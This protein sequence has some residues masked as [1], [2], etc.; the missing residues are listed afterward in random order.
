MDLSEIEKAL[1]SLDQ[2]GV[3]WCAP[4]PMRLSQ[5]AEEYFYLSAESSY[6]EQRWRCYPPQR[7]VMDCMSHDDIREL[8]VMKSARV[9]YTK[10]LGAA[11]CFFAQHKR[12]NQAVWQPTDEDADDFVK[13]EIDPMLRDVRV[14]ES[15]FPAF[16]QRDR[17]NTLR[18]KRF[19]GSVLHIRGGKAAKNYRR[20]TVDVAYIDELDGFDLD[21]E[22]EGSPVVLSAKRIEGATYPKHILGSTPK[23]KHYSMIEARLQQ[24]ERRFR[25]HVPCPGCGAEHVLSWGNARAAHGMKWTEGDLDSV[26]QLCPHCALLY[27]Q[28]DYLRVWEAGRWI[29]SD[30]V[31]IDPECRFR[32]RDGAEIPAPRS[33][34][35]QQWTAQLPQTSWSQIVREFLAA[36]AKAKTGDKS[37][38]KTFV[39]TTLGETWEEETQQADE[40]ELVKRAETY[41]LRECPRG[42]LILTAGV[43][44]QDNRWEIGV[45]GWGRGEESWPIDHMVIEGNPADERDWDRVDVYLQ[46]LFAH[47]S[48][49]RL[50]IEACAV[51]VGGHFTHQAYNFARLRAHRRLPG[52]SDRSQRFLAVHGAAKEGQPIKGRSSVQDVN[53]KGKVIKAGVRLWAIGTDTAKDL[54]FGRL[55]IVA[56]GPGKIHLPRALAVAPKFVE[57]EPDRPSVWLQQLTAEVRVPVRTAQGERWRWVKRGVRNE[58]LDCAVYAMFCAHLL[59]LPRYSDA[60]WSRLE[61]RVNP[62]QGDL[63]RDPPPAAQASPDVQTS[64]PL[65]PSAP[66]PPAPARRPRPG[67]FLGGW[68][69]GGRLR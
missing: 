18:A 26:R 68:M 5:W 47:Q 32:T 67:G 46:T 4:A 29:D 14:M 36:V 69:G 2:W 53:Y 10:M 28:Q 50:H 17:D 59:D 38:L 20:L 27:T 33:V 15:V 55:A 23:L 31:W 6:I 34:A 63:L 35:M 3:A 43:D 54:L 1:R 65:S 60:M 12:R 42:V 61:E 41:S 19:L 13:T 51:D 66:P 45:W 16:M 57:A 7:A 56:D 37:E 62:V 24:A 52:H 22:K 11:I 44:V 40:A 9:G 39:N 30:G 48:G 64:A 8:V 58:V 21:I 49:Q 25:W